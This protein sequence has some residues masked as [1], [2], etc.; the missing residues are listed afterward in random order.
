MKLHMNKKVFRIVSMIIITAFL[1]NVYTLPALAG[2]MQRNNNQERLVKFI[3]AV[4][5]GCTAEQILSLIQKTYP[6]SDEKAAEMLLAIDKLLTTARA[7]DS[8]IEPVQSEACVS[9][10][11]L[12]MAGLSFVILSMIL[13]ETLTQEEE[14]VEESCLGDFCVC[15]KKEV[16]N[17]LSK[18]NGILRSAGNIM[19]VFGVISSVQNC[20]LNPGAAD[21]GAPE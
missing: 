20:L 8:G 16:T 19:M 13:S 5:G 2:G 7:N 3:L 9:A 4:T 15:E 10:T 12:F 14:C 6:M 1:S 18:V 21:A 11:F 17:P